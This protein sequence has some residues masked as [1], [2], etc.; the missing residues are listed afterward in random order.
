MKKRLLL[1]VFNLTLILFDIHSQAAVIDVSSI[2][3]AISNGY[4]MFQELM[5][6]YEQLEMYWQEM[7]NMY[8]NAKSLDFS[9]VENF[10]YASLAKALGLNDEYVEKMRDVQGII[11][12]KS[13]TINGIEFSL[14]DLY[15]TNIYKKLGKLGQQYAI[16]ALQNLTPEEEQEFYNKTGM[17]VDEIE[18]MSAVA[19][20]LV[21][22]MKT[23]E[24]KIEAV[25]DYTLT[26]IDESSAYFN[27]LGSETSET[28][29]LQGIGQ[30]VSRVNT[31][32][33]H[34]LETLNSTSK[35]ISKSIQ[36]DQQNKEMEEN[37][38]N[39]QYGV[40]SKRQDFYSA[41]EGDENS[42]IGP[43]SFKGF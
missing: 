31:T 18:K 40:D 21:D 17:T 41:L 13:M 4:T 19:E 37:A 33:S 30:M 14:E 38:N 32:M 43:G 34:V 39:I 42:Y 27:K 3:T 5:S 25:K 7:Q 6:T 2:A 9:D 16:D 20:V 8:E 36:L 22:D 10:D 24:A 28:A 29:L 15:T 12:N 11:K 35:I 26:I 23:N 1:I